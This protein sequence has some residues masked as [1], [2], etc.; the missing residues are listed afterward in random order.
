MVC[1]WYTVV[2]KWY[3]VFAY[4]VHE[5]YSGIQVVQS[6]PIWYT[7]GIQLYTVYKVVYS[8]IQWCTV[9]IQWYTSSIEC[10][11]WIYSGIQVIYIWYTVCIE[12]YTVYKVVYS[13]VQ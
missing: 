8:A 11:Q 12:M 10:I 13:G 7:V 2:Y 9:N 6:V 4:C 1:M 3:T 5:V